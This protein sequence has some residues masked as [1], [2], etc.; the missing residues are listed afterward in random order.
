MIALALV[1]VVAVVSGLF[2]AVIFVLWMTL[3]A[4]EAGVRF[5][6]QAPRTVAGLIGLAARFEGPVGG[7]LRP[8]ESSL[9]RVPDDRRS[10][11]LLSAIQDESVE[12]WK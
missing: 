3:G 5:G 6:K 12:R 10:R 8:A 1:G 4:F 7:L 9:L 2:C 11:T